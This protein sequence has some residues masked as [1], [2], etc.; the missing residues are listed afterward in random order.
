MCPVVAGVTATTAAGAPPGAPRPCPC[1]WRAP[2]AWPGTAGRGAVRAKGPTG[3]GTAMAQPAIAIAAAADASRIGLGRTK[4]RVERDTDHLIC[5]SHSEATRR[6]PPTLARE[7]AGA[8]LNAPE[9]AVNALLARRAQLRFR[10]YRST[11][12]PSCGTAMPC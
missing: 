9:A 3:R 1:A 6:V 7:C 12:S 2:W 11:T 4:S 8:L 5:R 10:F